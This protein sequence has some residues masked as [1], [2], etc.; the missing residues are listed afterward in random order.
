[1]ESKTY[2]AEDVRAAKLQGRIEGRAEAENSLKAR[3][4]LIYKSNHQLFKE[5]TRLDRIEPVAGVLVPY[6]LCETIAKKLK[7]LTKKPKD[8]HARKLKY[9]MNKMDMELLESW[10]RFKREVE[11]G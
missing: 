1:M 7:E 9:Y 10:K 6:A 8:G 11:G 2:T 3:I 4:N 5:I